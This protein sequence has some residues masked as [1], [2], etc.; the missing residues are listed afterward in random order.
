MSPGAN[1]SYKWYFC[2]S[3][4]VAASLA[5]AVYKLLRKGDDSMVKLKKG[6]D[7]LA[8]LGGINTIQEAQT[9]FAKK[10]DQANLAKLQKI[11]NQEALLKIANAIAL[12]QPDACL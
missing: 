4:S 6:I 7:I 10:C 11:T 8:D 1:P 5:A 2:A 12:M 9:L 3:R